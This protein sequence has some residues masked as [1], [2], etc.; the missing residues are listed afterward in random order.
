ML[1]SYIYCV[2]LAGSSAA[3]ALACHVQGVQ[4]ASGMGARAVSK[5]DAMIFF[6]WQDDV[7][8]VAGFI[9]ACLERVYTSASPPLGD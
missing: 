4:Q 3:F 5:G 9:G 2:G 6:M 1:P 7:V 8:G